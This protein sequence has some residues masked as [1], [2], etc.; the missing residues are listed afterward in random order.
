M[1]LKELITQYATFRK[2][3]GTD[4]KSAESLLNT[5]CRRMGADIDAGD[6]GAEQ[7][8]LFLAGTGSVTRYWRRKYDTLR[9]FYRYATSRGFVDRVPLPTTVPKMPERFVPYIYNAD[10]LQRLINPTSPEK[11]GFRKLQPQT[12][13][14][15]LLLLYGAGLRISEAVALIQKDVD[16]DAAVITI[17]N[18]KFHKTRLVPVGPKL[19]QAMAQYAARRKEAGHL[20]CADAPFFVLRRG[21]PLSIHIVRAAFIRLRNYAGVRR[22][23]G[24]RYQPRL[25]DMRHSFVV[26]RLT[27]WYEQSGDVQKL[28]P[29]LAT[30]LGHVSIAATQV[31]ITM[32]PELLHAASVRFERYALPEAH[33]D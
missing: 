15:V 2:S 12:L 22:D 28:L 19:N 11:I 17:R 1:K 14:A 31:Y 33:R 32:T 30:Y 8:E 4:F 13:R 26:R 25:H 10:E 23:D 29:Q 3:M 20:Q 27:S 24:A 6:V 16:L 9:G 21:A 5:F 18:T 7:V